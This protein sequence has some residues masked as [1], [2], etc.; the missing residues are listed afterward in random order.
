MDSPIRLCF[1]GQQ[2]EVE[3]TQV[4]QGRSGYGCGTRSRNCSC[5]CHVPRLMGGQLRKYPCTPVELG[6]RATCI[7]VESGSGRGG[8]PMNP[9][10]QPKP[11]SIHAFLFTTSFVT[12]ICP[13]TLVWDPVAE[14]FH[15]TT[16]TR[17]PA[18]RSCCKGYERT[19]PLPKRAYDRSKTQRNSENIIDGMPI[20]S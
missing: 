1:P 14:L 2:L 17:S 13:I 12:S 4:K 8:R 5:D 9:N 19:S 11:C 6:P 18:C 16:T 10:S 7:R 15:N 20:V 3:Q